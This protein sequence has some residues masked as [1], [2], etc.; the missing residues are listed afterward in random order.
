MACFFVEFIIVYKRLCTNIPMS[1]LF[2]FVIQSAG[3]VAGMS[4]VYATVIGSNLALFFAY[5]RP[6]GNYVEFNDKQIRCKL[7]LP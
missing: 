1:V 3:G 7:R 4:A 2:A 6:C 5:R